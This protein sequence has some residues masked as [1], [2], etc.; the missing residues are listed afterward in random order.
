ML[1]KLTLFYT[2][3]AS[4]LHEPSSV[5][6]TGGTGFIGSN[7]LL[8]LVPR[9]PPVRFV[10]LDKLTYAGN[11]MNLRAIEEMKNYCFV[12]GDVADADLVQRIFQEHSITT[13]VHFAAESHVDRSTPTPLAFVQTHTL[14]TA[15][16]A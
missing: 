4:I 12:H 9:Y 5:L 1:P 7:F 3:A 15:N 10:N 14:G 13:V 16:P 8:R 6:V 11:L 2:D